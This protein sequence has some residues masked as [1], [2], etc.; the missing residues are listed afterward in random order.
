MLSVTGAAIEAT[1]HKDENNDGWCDVCRKELSPHCTE[2]DLCEYC[3]EYHGNTFF[4]VMIALFHRI[5]YFFS[6][7]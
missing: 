5:M 7:L 2:A 1:G 4:E 3:G 6:K